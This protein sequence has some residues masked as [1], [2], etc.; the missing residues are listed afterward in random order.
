M[1]TTPF[2]FGPSY[3]T[4]EAALLWLEVPGPPA[5]TQAPTTTLERTL[6][7]RGEVAGR[8]GLGL[9]LAA[10]Q[11]ELRWGA[12]CPRSRAKPVTVTTVLQSSLFPGSVLGPTLRKM[13]SS[14]YLQCQTYSR[15]L[16]TA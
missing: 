16:T 9:A 13:E 6:T 5:P 15:C 2:P 12:L 14:I 3:L 10:A 4:Q 11:D 7:A 1:E 8:A